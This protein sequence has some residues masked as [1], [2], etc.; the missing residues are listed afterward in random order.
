[1]SLVSAVLTKVS[2]R[3]LALPTLAGTLFL[4]LIAA[5][6]A[7]AADPPVTPTPAATPSP[8]LSSPFVQSSPS[9]DARGLFGLL[10]DPRQWVAAVFDQVLSNLVGTLSQG[11]H[12]LIATVLGSALNFITQTPAAGSYASPTVRAL[13]NVVRLVAD[14]ALALVALWGGFSVMAREHLHAPYHEAMELVPRLVLGAL[15]VNTS[16]SWGQIAIDANN[17]LCQLIGQTSLPAWERASRAS[18]LLADSVAT[19]IYLITGLLLVLQMLMRLALVDVLLVVAPLGLLCWVLP[20]TQGWARLWSH[21]FSAAVFTQF[22]Q[23]VTLKLGGSL[24]TDLTPMAPD[25]ALLAVFLGI[26]VLALTLKIPGLLRTHV[27]D[28]LGFARVVIYGQAAR[29]LAGRTQASRPPEGAA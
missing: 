9:S 7:A 13:W 19:L 3:R 29:A 12:D 8:S 28:G 24:V 2:G 20:Q 21:T 16:L 17:A 25:S 4:L 11:L 10:P 18:Q 22:L 5:H 15:L 27:G 14:A 6:P 1:M 26:A 23:V